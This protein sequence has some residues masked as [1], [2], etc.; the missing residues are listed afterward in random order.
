M[1]TEKKRMA[2]CLSKFY[3]I[4]ITVASVFIM[5][6]SSVAIILVHRSDIAILRDLTNKTGVS[7]V[8]YTLSLKFQL[9]ENVRVTK[10]CLYSLYLRV[11]MFTI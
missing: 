6:L 9:E 2:T 5:M 1:S 10:V 7:T 8:T 4:S 11:L 3:I